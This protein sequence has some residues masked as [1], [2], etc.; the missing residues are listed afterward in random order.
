M[1]DNEPTPNEAWSVRCIPRSSASSWPR[2][3]H[4]ARTVIP[5]K[6]TSCAQRTS[7]A[8]SPTKR[9]R[10]MAAAD[11]DFWI[12]SRTDRSTSR[13]THHN[14]RPLRPRAARSNKT[15]QNAVGC[16]PKR[17]HSRVKAKT[18]SRTAAPVAIHVERRIH[19]AVPNRRPRRLVGE[20]AG[21]G[22]NLSS[23]RRLST[24]STIIERMDPAPRQL[25]TAQAATVAHTQG[26]NLRRIDRRLDGSPVS[27]S[28]LTPQ[29]PSNSRVTPMRSRSSSTRA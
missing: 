11:L 2:A 13:R 28:R 23:R 22:S 8:P 29:P 16:S 20:N 6:A 15:Y 21:S 18:I 5:A 14:G 24:A 12:G 27:R 17:S 1:L 4:A 25:T 26:G 19:V 7:T 9:Y 3:T 10:S